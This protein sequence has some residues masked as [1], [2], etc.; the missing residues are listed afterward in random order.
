MNTDLNTQIRGYAE[1][2]DTTLEPV[3]LEELLSRHVA[4]E[5][6]PSRRQRG[7]VVAL[8]SAVAV[9]ILIGGVAWL[10]RSLDNPRVITEPT[11]PTTTGPS[12]TVPDVSGLLP[13]FNLADLPAFQATLIYDRNPDG[14]PELGLPQGATAV[15]EFSFAAP[16][17]MRREIV[18]MVGP[19]VEESPEPGAGSYVIVTAGTFVEYNADADAAR[20]LLGGLDVLGELF[21]GAEWQATCDL[22]EVQHLPDA[23]IAGRATHH[24]RCTN[25]AGAWELWVDQETGIVLQMTGALPANSLF[26]GS[27]PQ[28]GFLVTDIDYDP[29]FAADLFEL[30]PVE[31]DEAIPG[32]QGSLHAVFTIDYPDED[33]ARVVSEVWYEPGRGTRIDRLEGSGSELPFAAGSLEVWNDGVRY[34][35]DAATNTHGS[36]PREDQF[37]DLGPQQDPGED[38]VSSGEEQL[39]GRPV[40]HLSCPTGEEWWI[41]N[42]TGLVLRL[43]YQREPGFWVTALET[44]PA[45][46]ADIFEFVPPPGSIPIEEYVANA[47]NFVDLIPGELAPPWRGPLIDGGEVALEDLRGTPT[48]IL[49]WWTWDLDFSLP[50]ARDFQA[51]YE[52]WQGQVD[53]LS[54]PLFDDLPTIRSMIEQGDLTHPTVSCWDPDTACGDVISEEWGVLSGPIWVL[55][56]SVGMAGGVRR[57]DAASIEELNEMLGSITSPP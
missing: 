31:V 55:L 25:L 52:T 7:W 57:S 35:Y 37:I 12:T 14:Q 51:L 19:R 15:V 50:A 8:A 20:E 10:V 16:D 54:V 48:L 13:S 28:G 22:S 27:S 2:F 33:L 30:P 34:W 47:W 18:E 38:C 53:L 29:T 49:F 4:L 26:L 23:T 6:L 24:F 39:I 32:S 1:Y 43:D 3:E 42:E 11:T 9:L 40:T 5:P 44:E 56:D 41:D 17:R 45:F 21:W 46:P 36:E